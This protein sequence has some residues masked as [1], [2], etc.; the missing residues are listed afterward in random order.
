MALLADRTRG[1]LGTGLALQQ[2]LL[3]LGS[4]RH[5]LVEIRRAGRGVG[6][7]S[8]STPDPFQMSTISSLVSFKGACKKYPI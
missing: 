2:A 1:V 5:P 6:I 3:G 7:T 8:N 4:G